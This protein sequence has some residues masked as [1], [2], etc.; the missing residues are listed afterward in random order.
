[1]VYFLAKG[2]HR[3]GK[4]SPAMEKKGKVRGKQSEVLASNGMAPKV[5]QRNGN[6]LL[7]LESKG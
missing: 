6:L 7:S 4:V 2:K 1:M 5:T 3:G